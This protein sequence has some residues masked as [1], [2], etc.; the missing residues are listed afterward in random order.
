MSNAFQPTLFDSAHPTSEGNSSHR[1][2]GR[3]RLE[4]QTCSLDEIRAANLRSGDERPWVWEENVKELVECLTNPP[5]QLEVNSEALER[6]ATHPDE[7]VRLALASSAILHRAPSEAKRH[8]LRLLL[9]QVREGLRHGETWNPVLDALATVGIDP[10]P[11][12]ALGIPDQ[13]D[14]RNLDPPGTISASAYFERYVRPYAES[15]GEIEPGLAARLLRTF[16]YPP[17]GAIVL[18][19]TRINA[20]VVRS[21][22]D[23]AFDFTSFIA[24]NERLEPDGA[25]AFWSLTLELQREGKRADLLWVAEKLIE[26]RLVS[27][28]EL[29][30]LLTLAEE[31]ATPTRGT[32]DGFTALLTAFLR[33]KTRIGID[34]LKRIYPLV[35]HRPAAVQALLLH[36]EAT[37]ELRAWAARDQKDISLRVWIAQM[38]G[39]EEPV[40]EALVRS[41]SLKILLKLLPHSKGE[42]LISVLDQ[43]AR[44]QPD[45]AICRLRSGYAQDDKGITYDRFKEALL[46]Y[47]QRVI[48]MD[49]LR[50]STMYR[51]IQEDLPSENLTAFAREIVRQV[52]I[53]IPTEIISCLIALPRVAL[54][55]EDWWPILDAEIDPSVK[56]EGLALIPDAWYHPES[57]RVILEHGTFY[58]VESILRSVQPDEHRAVALALL[59]R[60][61]I[62]AEQKF[63]EHPELFSVLTPEDLKPLLMSPDRWLRLKAITWLG[64]IQGSP[65]GLEREDNLHEAN[66]ESDRI[67]GRSL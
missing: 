16:R 6:W 38:W 41:R 25:R 7:R 50:A 10:W 20:D 58:H 57:R 34:R 35:R 65:R 26:R 44:Q 5:S 27:L 3:L 22:L 1:R 19:R 42:K 15:L 49:P 39:D 12:A 55:I 64:Q 37:P 14:S 66:P 56:A 40:W 31:Y 29:D 13:P 23:Q 4:L 62:Q 48:D 9:E 47:F 17:L 8:A 54:R 2:F 30:Q 32:A 46:R 21:L 51:S 18:S 24:Q 60:F 52:V 67:N 28:D 43:I 33:H 11:V 63:K 59:H 53:R 36:S 45:N 61:P